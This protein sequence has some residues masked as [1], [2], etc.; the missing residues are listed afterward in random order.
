MGVK[1]QAVEANAFIFELNTTV[2]S[3]EVLD[4]DKRRTKG[5]AF[6]IFGVGDYTD[7]EAP[8]GIVCL[9]HPYTPMGAFA[10]KSIT[11]DRVAGEIT[12]KDCIEIHSPWA[13]PM[14]I[15]DVVLSRA[16]I[17]ND[18]LNRFKNTQMLSPKREGQS[19]LEFA[20]GFN[21]T[22][23]AEREKLSKMMVQLPN[24][25]DISEFISEPRM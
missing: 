25:D 4:G 20:I 6:P 16:I 11:L 24:V 21:A 5:I 17:P 13:R 23:K 19:P 10:P 9:C 1:E 8:D 7:F 12:L 22:T 2:F 18:A 15:G 3:V 14:N